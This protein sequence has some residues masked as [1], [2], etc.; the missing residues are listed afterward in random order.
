MRTPQGLRQCGTRVNLHRV[1]EGLPV[2]SLFPLALA[3]TYPLKP[4]LL[5]SS[6]L[7]AFA[8]PGVVVT[9]SLGPFSSLNDGVS[10]FSGE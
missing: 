5:R 4:P 7:E 3:V 6:L 9:T 8:H 2:G 1:A 10:E